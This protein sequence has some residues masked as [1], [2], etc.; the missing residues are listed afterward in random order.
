[1][2]DRTDRRVAFRDVRHHFT[3]GGAAVPALGPVDL[4]IDAGELVTIAGPS[5]CGKTT[6]LRLLA[7]FMRPTDGS[8]TVGDAPVRGPAA[9]RGVVF[10]QPTLF[11]WLSVRRNV[12]LGPRLR[13]TGSAER[14]AAAERYLELVGLQDFAEHRPYELSGG[15][16]QRCQI[17][18][19]LANEPDIVLMDEP[20][21][22]LDALT[23]ERLQEELLEIWRSTGRTILFITHSVDEAVF[24]GSRVLVMSPRP[25][26]IVLD[27]RAVFTDGG[28][29]VPAEEIRALPEYVA[30]REEVRGAIAA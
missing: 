28:G 8:I 7:G 5:G 23:R 26:R 12:E 3:V 16:Q 13:G 22:A 14:R 27:E 19:V 17:A 30:L 4:T 15:M 25:G 20:F 1:M 11:P 24:L 2:V 9:E 6:L 10:Q 18:R 29:R 21:G